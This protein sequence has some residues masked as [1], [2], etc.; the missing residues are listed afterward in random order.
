MLSQRG[1]MPSPEHTAAHVDADRCVWARQAAGCVSRP[2]S[3]I[4]A[5]H[6]TFYQMLFPISHMISR[7]PSAG[8]PAELPGPNPET[9]KPPRPCLHL[10]ATPGPGIRGPRAAPTLERPPKAQQAAQP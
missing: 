7:P 6:P 3:T 4:P 8:S 9:Q 10:H 5:A 1:R 2:K